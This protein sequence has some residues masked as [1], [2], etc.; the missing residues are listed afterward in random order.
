MK[1]ILTA[2]LVLACVACEQKTVRETS[3]TQTTETTT[4]TATGVDTSAV[5][6]AA[7]ETAARDAAHETGTAMET[8][9]KELQKQSK[10]KH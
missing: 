9:G 5:D 3:P 1:K 6:T 2:L 8:A 7:M 10:R 4:I